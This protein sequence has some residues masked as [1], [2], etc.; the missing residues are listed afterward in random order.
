MGLDDGGAAAKCV[1]DVERQVLSEK[2]RTLLEE[3]YSQTG[4]AFGGQS[5]TLSFAENR[6]LSETQ[7]G[8]DCGGLEDASAENDIVTCIKDL[9]RYEYALR[10]DAG[11]L[12]SPSVKLSVASQSA[13]NWVIAATDQFI[14]YFAF[15]FKKF[16]RLPPLGYDRKEMFSRNTV[17]GFINTSALAI[18]AAFVLWFLFE[19]AH[20]RR[21]EGYGIFLAKV[22]LV[23]AVTV[24][25]PAMYGWLDKV[26][27][28][29]SEA[30]LRSMSEAGITTLRAQDLSM[31]AFGSGGFN[32]FSSWFPFTILNVVILFAISVVV[33]IRNYFLYFVGYFFFPTALGLLAAAVRGG[34]FMEGTSLRDRANRFLVHGLYYSL[35]AFV[36]VVLSVFLFKIGTIVF[37]TIPAPEG[38]GR[39]M[40]EELSSFSLSAFFY[41]LFLGYVIWLWRKKIHPATGAWVAKVFSRVFFPESG[42]FSPA[43]FVGSLKDGYA[44]VREEYDNLKENDPR[45]IA[46]GR[47]VSKWTAP[48]AE[49]LAAVPYAAK[50]AEAVS[51]ETGLVRRLGKTALAFATGTVES[52]ALF[53]DDVTVGSKWKL[54]KGE[55]TLALERL[56]KEISALESSGDPASSARAEL[57]K[58]RAERIRR[59][60]E[61]E[62]ALKT[63]ESLGPVAEGLRDVAARAEA[64]DAA[65]VRKMAMAELENVLVRQKEELDGVLERDREARRRE[66]LGDI[67]KLEKLDSST[68]LSAEERMEVGEELARKKVEAGRLASDAAKVPEARAVDSARVEAIAHMDAEAAAENARK[69]A[70][71]DVAVA[72]NAV[73]SL[74]EKRASVTG[75]DKDSVALR[76]GIDQEKAVLEDFIESRREAADGNAGSAAPKPAAA[77]AAP[78]PVPDMLPET[79]EARAGTA[80]PETAAPAAS[81]D[82]EMSGFMAA[83]AKYSEAV[84]NGG[85][86]DDMKP[87]G[88]DPVVSR[89]IGEHFAESGDVSGVG[90]KVR[91]FFESRR[92]AETPR[93]GAE[94]PESAS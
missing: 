13:V 43:D 2:R 84:R 51:K 83:Y 87:F 49:A 60:A 33:L 81:E 66:L 35:S 11:I 67:R 92:P 59:Q 58:E 25:F 36:S 86:E 56:S 48:A 39:K 29:M 20:G 45:A 93:E 78:E 68:V 17:V 26:N 79:L 19:K 27:A 62:K 88:D 8:L 10:Q 24:G 14:G 18:V 15:G 77:A 72:E 12:G 22:G 7:A 74:E 42:T 46:L 71:A 89:I 69:S 38:T 4:S 65:P 16:D 9:R 53:E 41:L 91:E 23:L 70:A 47:T 21:P 40:V 6:R 3:E 63:F 61:D 54:A 50:A 55:R 75:S 76:A 44:K 28:G 94:G 85:D 90:K 31:D 80:G 32:R 64:E 34:D 52:A 1:S 82:P 73:S 5:K 37:S 57:L 30:M